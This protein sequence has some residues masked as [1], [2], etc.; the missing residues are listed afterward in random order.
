MD[1]YLEQPARWHGVHTRLIAVLGEV[2][3][4]QVP[5]RFFVDSEEE[6]Y[7]LDPGEPGR[8]TI[9]PDISVSDSGQGNKTPATAGPITTPMLVDLP[10]PE[11]VRLPYLVVRDMIEQRVVATIE[12]LSPTNKLPGSPGRRQFMRKR[13]RLLRSSA[14]WIEIDLLRGGDRPSEI[15]HRSDYYAALH[16]ASA[17]DTLNGRLEF[18]PIALRSPLPTIAVPLVEPL[19][20]APLDL[21]AAIELLYNRYQ[22]WRGIDYSVEPP[23]PAL[24]PDDATWV[25]EHIRR[26]REQ[27]GGGAAAR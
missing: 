21:Q 2:L 18:W 27:R 17:D 12:L 6:V 3:M 1:P 19:A 26:W 16:R 7:L 11:V 9:R 15:G 23:P 22:Y 10:E 14:H 13:K 24:A 25:A 5:D 20:D 8:V 4:R